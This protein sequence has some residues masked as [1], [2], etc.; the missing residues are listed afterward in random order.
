VVY[1]EPDPEPPAVD[2][3]ATAY[4][5]S[6]RRSGKTS[7][8]KRLF[9]GFIGFVLQTSD[10][11][12]EQTSRLEGLTLTEWGDGQPVKQTQ[13]ARALEDELERQLH[14]LITETVAH[15]HFVISLSGPDFAR[16]ALFKDRAE[17]ELRDYLERV[18]RA[19]D[20][21]L[22]A[23]LQVEVTED[24]TL[25][26]GQYAAASQIEQGAAPSAGGPYL[27]LL[28][29]G[30]RL[31]LNKP[32]IVLGRSRQS[33]ICLGEYDKQQVISRKHALIQQ[34]TGGFMIYDG[35]EGRHSTWG[36]YIEGERLQN[37]TGRL[38]QDGQRIILGPTQRLD[39]TQPLAGS[40]TLVF[41][42]G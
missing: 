41:H 40:L 33:D 26:L 24:P 5:L 20:Y 18:V 10:I 25:S 21:K 22:M 35:A 16:Y 17:A 4:P 42:T 14:H 36:T 8:V 7:L 6:R 9:N 31:P 13:L 28:P 37:G 23:P 12:E 11:V 34:E 1:A 15:N 30:E 27:E 32:T 19:R 3:E 29:N 2:G 38:L 39:P